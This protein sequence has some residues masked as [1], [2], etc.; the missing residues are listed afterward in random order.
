MPGWLGDALE[1]DFTAVLERDREWQGRLVD[2][3]YALGRALGRGAYSSQ[4]STLLQPGILAS[5][6]KKSG[7]VSALVLLL[8]IISVIDGALGSPSRPPRGRAAVCPSD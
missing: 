8:K 2:F 7:L 5:A 4:W 1:E 3:F 6:A